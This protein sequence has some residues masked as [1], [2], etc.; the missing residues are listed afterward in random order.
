MYRLLFIFFT[1]TGSPLFMDVLY[2]FLMLFCVVFICIA[3]FTLYRKKAWANKKL[4]KQL[5]APVIS[6]GIFFNDED[7][8]LIEIT[9]K[10]EKLLQRPKFRQRVINEIIQ[11][12]KNLSGSANLNLNKLYELL[13]LDVDSN[14]KLHHRHWHTKAK[15]IHELTI[16]QQ[17]KYAN[18]IAELTNH[19]NELVRN[20]AQCGMIN[21][22]GFPGLCFLDRTQYPISQ[23][24]QIQLLHKLNNVKPQDL[25]NIK[26]WLGSPN[27][28]VV[29]FS[30][31][32]AA[33][34][35]CHDVYD[36]VVC[37]LQNASDAIKLN[38]LEYLK[39]ISTEDTADRI[40]SKYSF[41][42]KTYRLAVL[43]A[44]QFIGSEKQVTFLLNQLQDKDDDIKTAAAKS[45]SMLHP[46][47]P[48]FLQTHLFAHQYPWKAIFLQINNER[49]A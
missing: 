35:N 7:N 10:I 41:E 33:I 15:A 28:S 9:Y 16:M 48:A 14:K 36:N 46:M 25:G 11:T 6:Q 20:E 22:L 31:K 44:L 17:M 13:E 39:K 23:W 37:C 30:I 12:K 1:S 4:W 43:E 32:L 18:E 19:Q 49:A 27:E 38:A 5:I 2:V 40:I 3:V 29:I 45:L 47:G 42:N 8:E 24:Q 34:Y 21:L 26:N